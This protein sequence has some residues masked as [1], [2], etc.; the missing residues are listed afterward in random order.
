MVFVNW[1]YFNKLYEEGTDVEDEPSPPAEWNDLLDLYFLANQ[2]EIVVLKNLL[3]DVL[4]RKFDE[5]M[6]TDTFP[7]SYTKKIVKNTASVGLLKA[8]SI[9]LLLQ[10]NLL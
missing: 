2:W 7:C 1:I 10:I 9:K 3:L 5:A 8:S 4:I 6:E